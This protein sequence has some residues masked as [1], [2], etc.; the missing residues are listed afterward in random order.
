MKRAIIVGATSGIG[1]EIA[2]V[3]LAQGWKIGIAGRRKDLLTA[4]QERNPEQIATQA[5]DV[6]QKDAVLKLNGLIE[7]LGGMDLFLLCSGIGKQNRDLQPEI[8]IDTAR[9]N[10]GGFIRMTN[11]AYTY[12]RQQ[13]GG[14]LAVISS[15]AG[16]KGLGVAPAYSATKRFQN[17][18]IDSLEQLAYMQKL[19]I[20]FTDI[21]PGFVD[22]ALLDSSEKTYPLLMKPE[23]VAK[24]A[25]NALNKKRRSVIIDWR[26]AIL[27]I[28]WRGI[29]SCLWKRLPVKN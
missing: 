17:I 15:I 29:P 22:T 12:F 16:T 3:L 21:K 2:K 10:V 13:G 26:Y 28:M 8:E 24:I 4:F 27:T 18:Y 9:T 6:T 14:H 25:V 19:K 7:Q 11:A 23:K 5:L 20:R 1:Q